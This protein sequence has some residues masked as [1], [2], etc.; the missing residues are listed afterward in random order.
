MQGGKRTERVINVQTL[1]EVFIVLEEPYYICHYEL[2]LAALA[3]E[4]A[5]KEELVVD[6]HQIIR[7]DEDIFCFLE[8][9]R[10]IDQQLHDLLYVVL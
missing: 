10:E 3:L 9:R 4:K 6:L 8:N 5:F 7:D 1:L 2:L